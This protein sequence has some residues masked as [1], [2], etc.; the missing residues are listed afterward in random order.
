MPKKGRTFNGCW[1]CR[2]R[3]VKCDLTQPYCTRCAKLGRKCQGYEIRLGWSNPISIS[4]KDGEMITLKMGDDLD[5]FQRRSI[6][7]MKFPQS[8]NYETYQQLND[9]LEEIENS[10]VLFGKGCVGPFRCFHFQKR[11]KLDRDVN[12]SNTNSHLLLNLE[13]PPKRMRIT[14]NNNENENEDENEIGQKQGKVITKVSSASTSSRKNSH[15]TLFSKTNRANVHYDLINYA[16]LTIL[17]IKGPDYKFNEQNM[18]HILYPKFFPNVDSDD[19]WLANAKMVNNKLYKKQ[20]EN[21]VIH[22]LFRILLNNFRLDFISISRVGFENNYIDIILLP[23]IKL[24]VGEFVC[25]EFA[26]WEEI[27]EADT[28][29]ANKEK[30]YNDDEDADAEE[31][32]DEEDDFE[33]TGG[34]SYINNKGDDDDNDHD[35]IDHR[36]LLASIKLCI[37]CL[38][39]GLSAFNLSRKT[40]LGKKNVCNFNDENETNVKSNEDYEDDESDNNESDNNESDDN[41]Y[42]VD[43]F[44]RI[45][46]E[47]RKISIKLLNRHLDDADEISEFQK[48]QQAL[49]VPLVQYAMAD[50]DTMLLLALIL[51]IELDNFFSVFENLDLIY[52]IG[53]LVIKTKFESKKRMETINRLLINIF[54]LKY[55]MYESTQAVNTVN[56]QIN[57]KDIEHNYGDLKDDYNLISL[58]DSDD[59]DDDDDFDKVYQNNSDDDMGINVD[60][61]ADAND[62]QTVQMQPTIKNMI[63]TDGS[64]VSKYVP[65]AYTISFEQNKKFKDAYEVTTASELGPSHKMK[66]TPYIATKFTSMFD[67]D[68][69]YLMFGI[70][71]DLLLIFHEL[72]HLANHKNIFNLRNVFPRNFPRISAEVEDRIINWNHTRLNW[73]LDPSNSFHEFLINNVNSFHYAVIICHHKLMKKNFCAEQYQD[74]VDK[75]LMYLECA[76]RVSQ[77]LQ[78]QYRPM[79]WN[80]LMCGSIAV[81]TMRQERIRQIW[82][83]ECYRNQPNYWRSKQILFEIWDRRNNGEDEEHLGFMNMIREWDICLSLG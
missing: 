20:G 67:A 46:M 12:I 31:D 66:F 61:D 71:R 42:E 32:D 13:P 47:L 24:I 1:T 29:V 48:E 83:F 73:S 65:T 57:D 36:H 43:E 7:L 37:I 4:E 79:F 78:L 72:I 50:Y 63:T 23:F 45:S 22:A 44:L 80:L 9:I 70:P 56:Y 27:V 35:K 30:D 53:D 15:G 58:V 69:I 59:D 11:S 25:W 77:K 64:G 8:M 75:C 26:Y 62:E 60:A 38:T 2:S 39:L 49:S 76:I 52:A 68:L 14:T 33:E 3:K 16:K 10:V 21:L 41:V 34:N 82:D 17:A 5:S 40:C 28:V 81:G 51:Q 55:F 54:K 19:D 74:L 18:M 6:E